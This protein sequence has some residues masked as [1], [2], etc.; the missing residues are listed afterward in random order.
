VRTFNFLERTGKGEDLGEYTRDNAKM[1][2]ARDFVSDMDKDMK[3]INDMVVAVR[4][5]PMSPEAK[6]DAL[7]NLTKAAN[8]LTANIQ[9]IRKA[10]E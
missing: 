4:N 10:V 6:R 2:L 3:E 9:K 7:T 1:L 5:S 8:G